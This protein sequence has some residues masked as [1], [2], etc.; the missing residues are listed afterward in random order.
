[1]EIIKAI[2]EEPGCVDSLKLAKN[3]WDTLVDLPDY[4]NLH[5]DDAVRPILRFLENLGSD[6][7]DTLTENE[8]A[9]SLKVRQFMVNLMRNGDMDQMMVLVQRDPDRF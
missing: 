6:G 8:K 2:Y 5:V 9:V 3:R 7:Q 4:R 1:M